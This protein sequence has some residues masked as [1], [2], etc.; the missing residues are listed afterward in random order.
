M[1]DPFH[2]RPR[3]VVLTQ[4]VWLWGCMVPLCVLYLF[5]GI[6]HGLWTPD[7]PREAEIAREMWL[8]PG[9]IPSLDGQPFIEK[10]P[11][12][13][14]TVAAAFWLVGHPSADVARL[15]SALAGS[16]TLLCVYLW[17]ARAQG[18]RCGLVAAL[19]LASSAQFLHS[20]HWVLLDPLLMVFT[21]L[22]A[23][24]AWEVLCAGGG[25]RWVLWF[26]AALVLALW[27]KGLIGPVLVIGGVFAFAIVER[28]VPWRRLAVVRGALALLGALAVLA[29]AIWRQ[30][31]SA[32]LWEW[33]WVNHIQRLVHPQGTGHEQPLP[34]YLW[35]L[36]M[37]ILPWLVPLV[38]V[39]RPAFWRQRNPG[40][41]LARYG[42]LMSAAMLVILSVAVTKRETYLLPLLPIL[43]LALAVPVAAVWDWPADRAIVR[44]TRLQWILLGCYLLAA[45]LGVL[46]VRKS[47]DV[48]TAAWLAGAL[49]CLL[50]LAWVQRRGDMR[51]GARAALPAAL[52]AALAWLVLLPHALESTKNMGPFLRRA[53]LL[54]PAG[55]PIYALNVDETLKGIAPFET[56]RS[57][58]DWAKQP[59]FAVRNDPARQPEWLLVQEFD[60]GKRLQAPANYRLVKLRHFGPGRALGLWQRIL[61]SGA[62]G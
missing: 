8:T 44:A 48:M 2:P 21:T 33:G 52:L 5:I 27:T 38:Y 9:V 61:A 1:I 42:L 62:Q 11:M 57:V 10:P 51:A 55:A 56:D 35:T 7:E 46:V 29:F 39:L 36:P 45:P 60:R 19:M 24:S 22:A 43:M 18:E 17:G 28:P 59:D 49:A 41:R 32:A 6:H 15:V 30:G 23:W 25:R 13:Y 26:Y 37:T 31:G 40:W 3:T 53:S 58:I 14:W 4:R 50:W 16:L 47:V 34:Y 20:T 12:Y 54:M